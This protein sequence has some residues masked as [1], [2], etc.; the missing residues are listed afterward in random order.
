MSTMAGFV[1]QMAGVELLSN[2][3]TR[4]SNTNSKYRRSNQWPN[5]KK[6]INV[7]QQTVGVSTTRTAAIGKAKCPKAPSFTRCP[8]IGTARYAVQARRLSNPWQVPV[9]QK[10]HHKSRGARWRTSISCQPKAESTASFLL[11]LRV[12]WV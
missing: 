6:C 11:V 5:L 8:R 3:E 10:I 4:M 12:N 1:T 2:S 7:R 9:R